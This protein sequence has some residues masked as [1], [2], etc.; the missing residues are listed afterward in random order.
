MQ[1]YLDYDGSVEGIGVLNPLNK[2]F[3]YVNN[4][5]ISYIKFFNNCSKN[6]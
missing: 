6:L 2:Y 5:L 4:F 3:M 1:N